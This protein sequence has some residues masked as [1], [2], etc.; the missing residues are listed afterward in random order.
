MH[1]TEVKGKVGGGCLIL[2]V[3]K[4]IVKSIHI[5]KCVYDTAVWIKI[6]KTLLICPNDDFMCFLY[7]PHEN[8]VY[9][10]FFDK[11]IFE[12]LDYDMVNYGDLGLI[13]LIGVG[14]AVLVLI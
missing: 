4:H 1:F 3:K 14:I 7:I 6:D 8:N 10:N 12:E 2:L 11:N 9:Y 13:G 5:L